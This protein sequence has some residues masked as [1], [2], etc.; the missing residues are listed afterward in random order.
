MR[1]PRCRCNYRT[2]IRF[3]KKQR[4]WINECLSC[5]KEWGL[6]QIESGEDD[7]DEE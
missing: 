2:K 3:V 5:G 1:C 7:K 4:N 6:D